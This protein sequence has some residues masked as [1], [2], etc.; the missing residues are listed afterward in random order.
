MV[1]VLN[2]ISTMEYM[3]SSDFET[4]EEDLQEVQSSKKFSDMLLYEEF[5]GEA[6]LII[7]VQ[8]RQR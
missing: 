4:K 7:T 5:H 8:R 3:L 2:Q 1:V 6:S